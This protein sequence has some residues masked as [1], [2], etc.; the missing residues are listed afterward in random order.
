M[1]GKETRCALGSVEKFGDEE[2]GFA[3]GGEEFAFVGKETRVTVTFGGK[4][5]RDVVTFV[6]VGGVAVEV[7]G[8]KTWGAFAGEVTLVSKSL[9]GEET[10]STLAL[11]GEV[12]L[13]G[14][15][16]RAVV[17]LDGKETWAEVA[18]EN[19][20]TLFVSAC[21]NPGKPYSS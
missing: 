5:S 12:A 8:E 15:E 9:G 16:T 2:T 18:L 13:A 11:I 21:R 6:F 14:I 10:R 7:T 3:L 19:V 20:F 17:A 4:V 1:G